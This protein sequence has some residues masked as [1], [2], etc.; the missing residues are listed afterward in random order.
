[1]RHLTVEGLAEFLR[2]RPQTHV[3]DVRF[4]HE[5][6]TG[7]I[8]GDHH[9]PWHP[10]ACGNPVAFL[11]QVLRVISPGDPVLV[12][13]TYGD[14]SCKAA[15]LLQAAGFEHVYNVLGGYDDL[16]R[17]PHSDGTADWVT[18]LFPQPGGKR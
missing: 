7:H 13:C 3:L 10:V 5:R 12:I 4:P 15:A 6:E 9:V 17:C 11:E 2:R 8:P 1:M 14:R 16:Q 18:N